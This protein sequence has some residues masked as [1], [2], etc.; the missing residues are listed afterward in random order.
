[1][2]TYNAYIEDKSVLKD[3]KGAENYLDV[4]N[5][6]RKSGEIEIEGTSFGR[7]LKI[8]IVNF[9]SNFF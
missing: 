3:F 4:Y 5:E 8:K 1:D 9:I 2:A 7:Q 6:K